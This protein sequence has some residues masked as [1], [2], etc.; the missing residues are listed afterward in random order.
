MSVRI[1]FTDGTYLEMPDGN[2]AAPAILG[3]FRDAE[4]GQVI[5]LNFADQAKTAHIQK[6][7]ITRIE[8]A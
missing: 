2:A 3:W 5:S 7:H 1:C 4:D 6:R 8:V